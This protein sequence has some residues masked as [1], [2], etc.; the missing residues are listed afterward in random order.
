M[1]KDKSSNSN[2]MEFTKNRLGSAGEQLTFTISNADVAYSHLQV[3]ADDEDEDS[4]D[5]LTLVQEFTISK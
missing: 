1:Y 5:E 3:Q 4:S 2:V